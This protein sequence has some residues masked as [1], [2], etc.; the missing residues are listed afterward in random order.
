[1]VLLVLVV[2]GG[3]VLSADEWLVYVGG[4]IETI[5]GD[6]RE[7]RG[8]VIFSLRGGP[9]VSV[10]YE[11]VDLATSAFITW[12]LNGR[13]HA[14]SRAGLP[15]EPPPTDVRSDAECEPASIQAVSGGET[16]DVLLGDRLERVHAACLDAPETQHLFPELGWF[17][18]ATVSAVLLEVK[19]GDERSVSSSRCPVCATTKVIAWFT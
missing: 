12:Q 2:G 3:S 10:P 15:P 9:L 18:R 1:L 4:G 14:P 11:D 7:R 5:N 16:F 6:W 17:G 13:R 8:E 19:P